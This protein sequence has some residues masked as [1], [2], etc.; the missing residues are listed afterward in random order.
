MHIAKQASMKNGCQTL[1]LLWLVFLLP[2]SVSADEVQRK[3]LSADISAQPLGAGYLIQFSMGLVLVL[4]AVLVLAWVLRRINRLHASAGGALRLLGVL[5]LGTRERVILIQV[6]KTQL[7][8]GVAPGRIQTLYV[9]NDALSG[10]SEDSRKAQQSTFPRLFD[11][12]LRRD[13][14]K[15]VHPS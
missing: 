5:S 15:E 3:V 7:L 2:L 11:A 9:L 4:T 8:L 10:V 1:K 14:A 13:E 12:A 6:G